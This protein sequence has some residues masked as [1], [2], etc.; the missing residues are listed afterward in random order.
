MPSISIFGRG[1]SPNPSPLRGVSRGAR[2]HRRSW[3]P[4]C[5]SAPRWVGGWDAEKTNKN[6]RKNGGFV[7]EI[8][9]IFFF[10]L[11]FIQLRPLFFVF[12]DF[13]VGFIFFFE[14]V[15]ICFFFGKKKSISNPPNYQV[16]CWIWGL[17]VPPSP[18]TPMFFFGSYELGWKT[19]HA[20]LGW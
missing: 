14:S 18:F 15:Y 11:G 2:H 3:S 19:R 13:Q 1:L 4:E 7:A 17:Y 9:M 16:P 5:H 6:Y 20:E 10:K 8:V 12:G